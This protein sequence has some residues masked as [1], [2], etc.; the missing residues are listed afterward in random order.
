[1]E[2]ITVLEP[3]IV[4]RSGLVVLLPLSFSIDSESTYILHESLKALSFQ[5]VHNTPVIHTKRFLHNLLS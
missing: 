3:R 1:M 5:F 2:C 4:F